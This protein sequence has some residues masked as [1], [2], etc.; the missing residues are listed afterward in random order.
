MS[1]RVGRG[2]DIYHG[3]RCV[4][5]LFFCSDGE[6]KVRETGVKLGNGSGQQRWKFYKELK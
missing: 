4:K 3:D 6:T 1:L 2:R 5:D